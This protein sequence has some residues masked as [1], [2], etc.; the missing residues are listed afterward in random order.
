M[1]CRA[2]DENA[3]CFFFPLYRIQK[4]GIDQ[5]LLEVSLNL[6]SG[7]IGLARAKESVKVLERQFKEMQPSLDSIAE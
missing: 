3:E 5:Y 1:D 6:D 2:N 7:D 4:E